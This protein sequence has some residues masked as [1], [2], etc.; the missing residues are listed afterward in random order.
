MT[1]NLNEVNDIRQA[2]QQASDPAEYQHKYL[3]RSG[4]LQLKSLTLHV[5]AADVAPAI[6]LTEYP[7]SMT[8]LN[9]PSIINPKETTKLIWLPLR[10]NNN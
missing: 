2:N 9:S 10:K 8:G 5:Y 1:E 7:M 6:W 3:A 4:D